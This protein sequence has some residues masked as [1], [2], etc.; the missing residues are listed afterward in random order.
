MIRLWLK[1]KSKPKKNHFFMVQFIYLYAKDNKIFNDE[2]LQSS[3]RGV[4]KK[5]TRIKMVNGGY[6]EG[7]WFDSMRHDQGIQLLMDNGL[8]IWQMKRNLFQFRRCTQYIIKEIG[9]MINNTVMKLIYGQMNLNM[10]YSKSFNLYEK[11]NQ[12]LL[13]II[14]MKEISQIMIQKVMENQFGMMEK[15]ML[16]IGQTVK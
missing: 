10:K 1:N 14:Y 5:Q 3:T 16:E 2:Y 7:D 11:E 8:M 9:L 13:I 4:N 12:N 6:Y 15:L